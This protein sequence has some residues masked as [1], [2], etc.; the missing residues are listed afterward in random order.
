MAGF[1][2]DVILPRRVD[3]LLEDP[4]DWDLTRSKVIRA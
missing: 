2:A 4:W 3:G 1:R